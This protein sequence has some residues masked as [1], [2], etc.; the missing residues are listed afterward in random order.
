MEYA[1]GALT[2]EEAR[3]LAEHLSS[4]AGCRR[5]LDSWREL[6]AALHS[7]PVVPEPPNFRQMVMQRIGRPH[8]ASVGFGWLQLSLGVGFSFLVM[9]LL[10]VATLLGSG[11]DSPTLWEWRHQASIWLEL[12][13][14]NAYPNLLAAGWLLVGALAVAVLGV[15]SAD[16]GRPRAYGKREI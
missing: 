9:G 1:E 2:G 16:A 7:F 4:C 3:L 12:Y 15:V 5:E 14:Q 8:Q 13:L 6:E 10:A 11:L